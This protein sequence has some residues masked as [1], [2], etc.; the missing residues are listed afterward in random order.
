MFMK[1]S[2]PFFSIIIPT[3][4]RPDRLKACLQAIACSSYARDRFEVIV[5]DDGSAHPPE[6]IVRQFCNGGFDTSFALAAGEDREL[7]DRWRHLGHR[8]IYA[9]EALVYHSHAMT[10]R[11]FW[12]QH[13]N[14]GCGA[15]SFHQARGRRNL[16]DVKLEPLSFYLTLL[17]YPLSQGDGRRAIAM[18]TLLILSQAANAAGFFLS[19]TRS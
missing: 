1:N 3:Y 17:R 16:G 19:Q 12:R 14:Y 7:C 11:K 10:L 2:L 9:S 5:V 4:N 13:F 15:A 18:T 6:T 8:I